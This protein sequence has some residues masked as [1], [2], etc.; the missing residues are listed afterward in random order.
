MMKNHAALLLL[1]CLVPLIG[2]S[3]TAV[4]PALA[5]KIIDESTGSPIA[6][7]T[8]FYSYGT[9]LIQPDELALFSG[10]PRGPYRNAM[11]TVTD[12]E[13]GFRLERVPWGVYR[14]L[15][16]A[17]GYVSRGYGQVNFRR[18]GALVSV[19]LDSR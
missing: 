9:N 1:V 7:A 15:A 19:A 14:L 4:V 2:T 10:A 11:S 6:G 5:G 13:G 18:P 8:V 17:T 3:Q 16:T 12:S